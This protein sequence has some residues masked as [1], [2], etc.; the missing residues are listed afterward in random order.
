MACCDTQTRVQLMHRTVLLWHICNDN[1]GRLRVLLYVSG[2][3]MWHGAQQNGNA[4]PVSYATS[5][6]HRHIRIGGFCVFVVF[7]SHE[8]FT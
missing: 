8:S 4:S 2:V 6:P 7:L 3:A 5:C 1:E